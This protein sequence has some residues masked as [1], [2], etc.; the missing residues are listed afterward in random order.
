MSN[1]KIVSWNVNGIRS[2]I[3]NDKTSTQIKKEINI[4]LEEGSPLF[5]LKKQNL[6][7]ICLQETRCSVLLSN[8]MR[9]ENYSHYFNESKSEGARGPNRYSGTAIYIKH[10][11]KIKIDKVE[12]QIE[13]YDDMEG[14]IIIL[15]F[16]DFKNVIINVYVPNSGTNYD[17]RLIFQ[18]AIFKFLDKQK[19]L[20]R[21]VIYCGDFNVAYRCED[22]HF[23]YKTSSTY[24]KNTDN[25]VG[26]LP[27]ERQFIYKLINDLDFKD[28]YIGHNTQSTK[29]TKYIETKKPSEFNGFTWWDT[30]SKKILNPET[31]I[32]IGTFR[33]SNTGWRIDY[34]FVTET[35]NVIYSSVLKHIGE[36]Y[37]PQGSD[38]A[39]I[40]T[41]IEI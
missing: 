39:P 1:Y 41:E 7:F 33:Y 23:N 15:Y 30:R 38:H 8:I 26:Y 40:M 35:I 9:L 28:S 2:R 22:I 17:N 5:N 19:Q 6:D 31:N 14:R 16:N 3:F 4:P 11:D 10:C 34:I 27:D 12:Y 37:S 24:K 32:P 18:E 13:G 29:G 20:D 25:I 21:N 36:E